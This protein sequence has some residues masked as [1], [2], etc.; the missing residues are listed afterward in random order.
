MA[1]LRS[2]NPATGETIQTFSE[3]TPAEVADIAEKADAAFEKWRLVPIHERGQALQRLAGVLTKQSARLAELMACEMG[4]PIQQGKAEIE[5]CAWVCEY[6][7]REGAGFL[8]PEP[9]A[10]DAYKSA[11][12]FEPL[13]VIL[14]I[15]PWNFPF[16]QVFRFAAP[17]LLAG[18]AALLK[19]AANVTGCALAIEK[20]FQEAGFP[21]QLFRTLLIRS[22]KVNP[23]IE[24]PR[25]KAVTL[26]GSVGAGKSVAACAGANLK[27]SVLELGGSDPYLVLADADL[28][29]AAEICAASRLINSGQSCIAAKRFL[30][31]DAVRKDFEHLFVEKMKSKFLGDPL[32]PGTEVGPLARDDL[33][34]ALHKQVTASLEKG[35]VRL[36]GGE[37]LERPGAYYLPTV[38]TN[39]APGMPAFDEEL[40]G[41]VAAVVPV[42]D[43]EEAIRLANQTQFG[44]GAAVFTRDRRRGEEIAASRLEAGSCFVNSLVKSDPRLPF[45]GIKESGYGRE[46]GLFGIREFVNIKTVYVA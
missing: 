3:M 43:E 35:A 30:V 10:T 29:K 41:P 28:E 26:T 46:L 32:E 17:T 13:G 2:I 27:K 33:R 22:D 19:H 5:K 6:Y 34:H 15:M 14:A 36:L 20:L 7:A 37:E 23:L 44:L 18:N 8:R 16:W 9:I 11:V 21:A 4:K 24:N 25:V 40:F 45:G 42:R 1:D 12:R 31:V 38:L 39:V